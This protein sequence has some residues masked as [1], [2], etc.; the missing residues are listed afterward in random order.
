MN[1]AAAGKRYPDVRFRVDADRIDA[2][3]SLFEGPA[4]GVPATL[5]TAAEFSVFPSIVADPELGLDL[6]RVVHASQEYEYTRP[7]VEGES[8]TVRTRIAS[9]RSKGDTGFLSIVTELV[10]AAGDVAATS[11]ST[12][13]E[14]GT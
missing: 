1:P 8:L 4:S 2:F 10:D 14:R 3:R 11:T 7:L 9:V 5:A 13:V 12:M 6:A